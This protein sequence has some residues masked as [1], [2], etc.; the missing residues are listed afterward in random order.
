MNGLERYYRL[1]SVREKL[2]FDA[3]RK[4]GAEHIRRDQRR[5]DRKRSRVQV[6][7]YEAWEAYCSPYDYYPWVWGTQPGYG[8]AY[9]AARRFKRMQKWAGRH[10]PP[11]P[12]RYPGRYRGVD[13]LSE[14]LTAARIATA[15]EKTA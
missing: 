5:L 8:L 12:S 15:R 6:R 3:Y 2:E 14:I 7:A 1:S 10:G 13:R 11:A 4:H 9:L